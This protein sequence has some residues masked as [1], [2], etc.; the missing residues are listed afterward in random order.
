MG[1]PFELS[2]AE[3]CTNSQYTVGEGAF[4]TRSY[5]CK[6]KLVCLNYVIA[7]TQTPVFAVCG[8]KAE[9]GTN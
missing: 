8:D 7:S 1:E 3:E 9:C 5:Q 6:D 2:D 4:C